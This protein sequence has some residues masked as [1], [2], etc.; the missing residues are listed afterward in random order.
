LVD[1]EILLARLG[2]RQSLDRQL[3][4]FQNFALSFGC[5]SV[6]GGLL[7]MWGTALLSGGTSVTIWG[8]MVV[9]VLTLTI[10]LSLAEICSAFPT[11]GGLYF[12]TAQLSSS[13]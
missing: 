5:C 8:Y 4:M 2:Y 13:E 7:P 6:L 10:G 9:A 1:D 12:W 3:S 11:A